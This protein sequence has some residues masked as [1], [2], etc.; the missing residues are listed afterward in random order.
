MLAI[1]FASASRTSDKPVQ[2]P[3]LIR[4]IIKINNFQH[5]FES[6]QQY[7]LYGQKVASLFVH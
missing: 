2:S 4:Y 3:F 1:R 5:K 7:R 6:G